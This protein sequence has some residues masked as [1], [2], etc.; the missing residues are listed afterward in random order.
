MWQEKQAYHSAP[1]GMPE[2]AEDD[3]EVKRD[4]RLCAAEAREYEDPVDKLLRKYS[5]WYSL[6][7]TV[8][9]I[10]R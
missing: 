10:L 5:C 8:A 2:I 7:G 9:W 4:A 6:I 3:K 1:D